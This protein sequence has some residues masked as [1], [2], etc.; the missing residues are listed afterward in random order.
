MASIVSKGEGNAISTITSDLPK[1][2]ERK[3]AKAVTKM[4]RSM[5]LQEKL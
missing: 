2:E 4:Y 3:K 5:W 1:I